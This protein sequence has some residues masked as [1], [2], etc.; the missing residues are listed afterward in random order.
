MGGGLARGLASQPGPIRH[1]LHGHRCGD[2]WAFFD[3]LRGTS[4]ELSPGVARLLKTPPVED[5][6]YVEDVLG[7]E[8][9]TQLIERLEAGRWGATHPG[10]EVIGSDGRPVVGCAQ[11]GHDARLALRL[12]MRISEHLPEH[13]E[14]GELMGLRPNLRFVRYRA[15]HRSA[16]HADAVQQ[17]GPQMRSALTLLLFLNDDFEGGHTEFPELQRMVAPQR[18]RALV[19]PQELAH[20]GMPVSGGT[21]YVLRCDVAYSSRLSR[22]GNLQ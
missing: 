21:K 19:F 6:W 15:G 8:E 4:R 16:I 17:I 20:Q 7:A 12:Y 22:V 1:V 18:G 2:H 13:L 3:P 9:C 5:V 14:Q 10:P 11:E